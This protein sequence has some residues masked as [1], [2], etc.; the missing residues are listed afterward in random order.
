MCERFGFERSQNIVFFRG[1]S[2]VIILIFHYVLLSVLL[3]LV[4]VILY[5]ENF[6]NRLNYPYYSSAMFNILLGGGLTPFVLFIG[7]FCSP[8]FTIYMYDA[9]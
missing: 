7:G 2:N 9:S 5:R 4:F 3:N 8:L 6:A 1:P